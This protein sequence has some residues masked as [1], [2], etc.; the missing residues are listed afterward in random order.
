MDQKYMLRTERTHL[1]APNANIIMKVDIGGR[2]DIELLKLAIAS[3]VAANESLNCKIV[4]LE[5]GD[6]GYEKL[7][8]PVYSVEVSDK[9]WKEIVREQER[10]MYDLALGELIR[11]FILTGENKLELLIIAHHLAGDGLSIAYLIEDIMKSLTGNKLE[12][13]PLQVTSKEHFPKNSQ[14]NP[15]TKMLLNRLNKKW[16]RN[17]KVFSYL[18]Y[19]NMFEEYWKH[20]QTYFCC[21]K[22][23]PNELGVLREKARQSKVSLNSLIT[24][25]FIR[26]FGKKAYTG[27]AVS[28][29][30]KGN[31]AMTNFVS[32]SSFQ[33]NYNENKS[34]LE[35]AQA[36]HKCI[37]KILGNSRRKYFVLRFLVMMDSTLMDASS[38][39][40]YGN[41]KNKTAKY[42]THLLGCD[43]N[44][45]DISL[46]NLTKLDIEMKYGQYEISNF[47]FV[48][49]V[50]PYSR[51]VIGIATLGDE[52]C[53]SK[54]VMED[55]N[56]ENEKKLF[57]K[58]IQILKSIQ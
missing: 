57:A 39:T 36:V 47:I 33:Y 24:T 16:R 45:R 22:L 13:K 17:G 52:M 21:E 30:E 53:I 6:A 18:E 12:F 49:P 54:H 46:T 11:F 58:A 29:R 27:F 25:A 48:A 37:Y 8:I 7:E 14:M 35:N 34:F 38:M 23:T 19:E 3:A 40:I 42:F 1:F 4:L 44:P 43:G 15:I 5:N 28:A 31:H 55:E 50:V 10:K 51:G 9:S 32:G 2:P 20:R 26:A 56:V 41:Y